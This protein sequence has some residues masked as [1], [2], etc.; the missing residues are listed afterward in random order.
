[1]IFSH[2]RR[3]FLAG[4]TSAAAASPAGDDWAKIRSQF[5][6]TEERVPM[7]AANLCPSPKVVADRVTELTRNIDVD[8]SFQNRAKFKRTVRPGD[9]LNIEVTLDAFERD[10]A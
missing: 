5:P 6:F 3:T 4:L 8:C 10:V 9:A 1:M 2:S 7:N